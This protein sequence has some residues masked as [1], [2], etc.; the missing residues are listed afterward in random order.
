MVILMF[1][2]A[3]STPG[4]KVYAPLFIVFSDQHATMNTGKHI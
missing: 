4:T 1:S 3:S 2:S